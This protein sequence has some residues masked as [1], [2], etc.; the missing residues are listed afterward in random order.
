MIKSTS[1]TQLTLL[2]QPDR[3][4]GPHQENHSALRSAPSPAQPSA[5]RT[6]SRPLNPVPRTAPARKS[7][8]SLWYCLYLPQLSTV[9]ADEQRECLD[10]LAQLAQEF[11]SAISLQPQ[12][13]VFEIRSGLKYFGGAE[14]LHVGFK[15]RARALLATRSLPPEFAYAACPTI[16][17]SLLLARGGGNT[18]V[19]RKENLNSAL[20]QLSIET[21]QLKPEPH[22]RLINMGIR[23]LGDLWR[24]PPAGLRRRFGSDFLALINKALGKAPEPIKNYLPPPAFVHSYELPYEVENLNR[25]RP[26][27]DEM[28]A[29]LCDFLRHRELCASSIELSLLHERREA[30]Q[31]D[32]G[33]RQASRSQQH[34]ML[35]IDTHLDSLQIPA[36]VTALCLKVTQFDAFM[37]H[38]E[39]LLIG[40]DEAPTENTANSLAQFM[41]RLQARLGNEQVK[42]L[43]AVEEH[44]P[45][46]ANESVRTGR[47]ETY[48]L[49][50]G[51]SGE[52]PAPS[53]PR[54]LWL[55]DEPLL[56]SLRGGSLYHRQAITLL[57]GPER[58]EARWWSGDEVCRDY[59][60]AREGGGSRLWIYRE[61]G[62]ERHWYLHG[63]FA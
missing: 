8:Q 48:P 63:Y 42:S 45:E 35:L 44:C 51:G 1:P 24:L 54:P 57:S 60:V 21:L 6:R 43:S 41:E 13:I 12:A 58:I 50:L 32:V 53:N 33:L 17:G 2:P 10:S 30:T 18:L 55:L 31:V 27:V 14:S 39:S 56:L 19:Y 7:R 16:E 15:E 40:A 11:S 4:S 36:P 37:S 22:R 59:Y 49:A 38:S 62:G 28:I 25:L 26:V 34:L 46:Y 61:R 47:N 52:T 5:E 9:A 20:G 3:R 23:R 29:Q